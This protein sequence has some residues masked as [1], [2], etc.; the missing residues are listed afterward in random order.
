MAKTPKT[1][2]IVTPKAGKLAPKMKAFKL[3]SDTEALNKESK[4]LVSAIGNMDN[5]IQTYLMSEIQHIA[6][7]KNRNPTRLNEFFKAITG[8]GAR[9]TAMSAFVQECGTVRFNED[10]K[11][12]VIDDSK[13]LNLE[14]AASKPWFMFKPEAPL[15]SFDLNAQVKRLIESA[16]KLSTEQNERIVI[17]PT[18]L[19][20]LLNLAAAQGIAFE[21]PQSAEDKAKAAAEV[22][23]PVAGRVEGVAA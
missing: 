16:L 9:V 15:R 21:R 6:N 14:L 13:T 17:A 3:I 11:L 1:V 18:T 4:L 20:A 7:P 19:E 5:R 2:K 10:T 22:A 8:K 23:A 12:F